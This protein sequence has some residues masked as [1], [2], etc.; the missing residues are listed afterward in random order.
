MTRKEAIRQTCQAD[1]LRALG[2]TSDEAEALRR[3]SM[4]LQRW[5]AKECGIDHGCIE[6][7][8]TTGKPFWY[9]S[10]SGRR[11]PIPDAERGA[12][13]RLAAIIGARNARHAPYT[14]VIAG[15]VTGDTTTANRTD[16]RMRTYLQTDPRGAALY[17]IRPGDVPEGQDVSSYYNR[18]ICVY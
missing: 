12:E 3:I 2:F 6:R 15:P 4:R 1:T 10:I 5:Y 9:N 13:K 8:E 18:G 16:N 7:D 11:F 14:D 17:I